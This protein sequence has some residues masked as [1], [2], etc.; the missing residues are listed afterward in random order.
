MFLRLL[1]MGG[2]CPSEQN[3]APIPNSKLAAPEAVSSLDVSQPDV[4]GIFLESGSCEEE[5]FNKVHAEY[6]ASKDQL[7]K[8]DGL[9]TDVST[10]MIALGKTKQAIV[11]RLL[12]AFLLL[13]YSFA[14]LALQVSSYTN[15]A[16]S[17]PPEEYSFAW[18]GLAEAMQALRS[19]WTNSPDIKEAFADV[20]VVTAL[21]VPA[22]SFENFKHEFEHA[23]GISREMLISA[24]AKVSSSLQRSAEK[25]ENQI[26]KYEEY[27]SKTF[28]VERCR[29]E[30]VEKTWD[31]FAES[32]VRGPG[33]S[34]FCLRRLLARVICH[35]WATGIRHQPGPA[36]FSC[37][38]FPT[39]TYG[40]L[41]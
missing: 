15:A 17:V 36:Q 12:W 16:E 28:D 32:W 31:G 6:E 8:V 25:L 3:Q 26:P 14:R 1:N 35:P 9:V 33:P 7:N 40:H 23:I 2:C 19:M 30:F 24:S 27:V 5:V 4:R 13:R 18:H 10:M 22:V 34:R 29:T 41:Q 11:M 38:C 39:N 37:Y 21:G 20:N